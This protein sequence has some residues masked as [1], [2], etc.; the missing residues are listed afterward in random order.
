MMGLLLLRGQSFCEAFESRQPWIG[1][2]HLA[3][4][5]GG[6]SVVPADRTESAALL[7]AEGFHG[8]P[9]FALRLDQSVQVKEI[10]R[11][12]IHLE[13]VSGEFQ[14]LVTAAWTRTV[15]GVHLALKLE[16][17]GLQA[18]AAG[19]GNANPQAPTDQDIVLVLLDKE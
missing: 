16:G 5:R 13:I 10:V 19:Q 2:T 8:K 6:V 11:V 9:Q 15:A 12:E 18:T 4:A 3:G 14:L 17:E 7:P 1:Q